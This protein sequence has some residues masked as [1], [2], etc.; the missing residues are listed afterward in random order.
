KSKVGPLNST[1]EGSL[2]TSRLELHLKE[3]S[4]ARCIFLLQ[5]LAEKE[6]LSVSFLVRKAALRIF[7]F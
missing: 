6:K 5:K 1:R 7:V 3:Q 4:E 2:N